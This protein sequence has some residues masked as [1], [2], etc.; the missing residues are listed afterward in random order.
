M[1]V[2]WVEAMTGLGLIVGPI[3]GSALYSFFGYSNTFYIYGSFLVFL[4]C[5]IKCNFP[6]KSNND[7]RL[8]DI[9]SLLLEGYSNA[10]VSQPIVYQTSMVVD[11]DSIKE[12]PVVQVG[13]CA[14]L[15]EARFTLAA[16]SSALCYFT[17][18]FMEPILA[19]RLVEFNLTQLQI[20]SFF[21][22]WPLFYIPASIAVQF[23]PHYVE[24]RV[25][26]ILSA[27]M[28]GVAFIFVG[29]SIMFRFP[30]TLVMMGVG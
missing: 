15:K 5:V 21:A 3:V 8:S 19:Q 24:K 10:D 4:A 25:T 11:L 7:D 26:I 17:Y 27:I 23:V 20:G 28:S 13:Y 18:S 2:G 30:D 1:I 6:E 22:I 14:L 9:K 29:P 12:E 16:L